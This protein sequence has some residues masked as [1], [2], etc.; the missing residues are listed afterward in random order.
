[1]SIYP[2]VPDVP[3]VPPVLRLAGAVQSTITLLTSDAEGILSAFAPP[4]WGIIDDSGEPVLTAD[5]VLAFD[6][7]G[8]YKIS[9]YPVEDGGFGSY[10]KVAIPQ[11]CRLV[12]TKGGTIDERNGFLNDVE[13]IVDS[14]DL[15]TVLVPEIYYE[16]MNATHFDYRRTSQNGV[17]LV[18]VEVWLEEVRVISTAQF[19]QAQ[20]TTQETT[21]IGGNSSVAP[22][23]SQPL[24]PASS[25]ASS[26]HTAAPIG[27][28][29]AAPSGNDPINQGAVQPQTPSASQT[30]ALPLQ[31]TGGSL[32]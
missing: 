28:N 15:Y 22:V 7:R 13:G 20:A 29:A 1:M 11:S 18:T 32:A 26:T 21:T 27:E 6:F 31:A 5:S 23:T 17:T 4:Q 25:A 2:D 24:G 19:S 14:L 3:G 30:K 12:F 8:E 10:N 16:N 9:D